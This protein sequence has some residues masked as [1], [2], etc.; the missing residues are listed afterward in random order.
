MLFELPK[1]LQIQIFEFDPT[2]HSDHKKCLPYL[3]MP[4]TF[5]KIAEVDK[6]Y[7]LTNGTIAYPLLLKNA[8]PDLNATINILN[9]CNCC[10][11]HQV[12]KP[13]NIYE[14]KNE[15]FDEMNDEINYY[16][17]DAPRGVPGAG[18]AIDKCECKCRHVSRW[19]CR[20]NGNWPGY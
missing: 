14:L 3:A 5:N 9:K 19:L 6:E 2:Y 13:K 11:R 17:S 20:A 16:E 18:W 4:N 8:F 1:E 15:L 12:K 10:P 7:E